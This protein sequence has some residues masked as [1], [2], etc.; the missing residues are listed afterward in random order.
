MIAKL[1]CHKYGVLTAQLSPDMTF[2]VSVGC[3]HD[4]FIYL[5]NWKTR[6][7]LY[8][9][10]IAAPL[11][12]LA[13][14]PQSKYFV[15]CGEKH[16]KFWDLKDIKEKLISGVSNESLNN[17]FLEGR[18]ARLGE[19]KDTTL[20]D[21]CCI[22]TKTEETNETFTYAMTLDGYLLMF[23]SKGILEKWLHAKMEKGSCIRATSNYLI[24]GGSEGK[25]RLF[26]PITLKHLGNISAPEPLI[27]QESDSSDR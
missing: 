19:H 26:E 8:G 7:R 22:Q 14:D 5:W 3:H 27:D 12:S 18:S 25:V 15:T 11:F 21:I 24:C 10:K 13:F 2:L 20:V 9:V 4:G 17:N 16:M 23:N 1:T 6:Q